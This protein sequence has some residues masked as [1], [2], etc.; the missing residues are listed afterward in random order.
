MSILDLRTS[1]AREGAI[2]RK[3]GRGARMGVGR[4]CRLEIRRR[5]LNMGVFVCGLLRLDSV[6]LD[7]VDM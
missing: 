7:I 2:T 4:I 1:G 5:C 3:P 6:M